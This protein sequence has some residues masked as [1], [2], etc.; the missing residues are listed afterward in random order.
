[1]KKWRSLLWCNYG[2]RNAIAVEIRGLVAVLLALLLVPLGEASAAVA[3]ACPEH[4]LVI[5]RS[6]NANIVVYDANRGAGGDFSPSKPV[7]AYWLLKGEKSKRQELN[8]VEWQSAYGFD[9][10]SGRLRF[11][12]VYITPDASLARSEGSASG[13]SSPRSRANRMRTPNASPVS[14]L[15]KRSSGSIS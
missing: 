7:V 2:L 8:L 9:V 15:G 14:A 11:A 10:I 1:M 12:R 13:L 6:K 5:E 3:P 4:L